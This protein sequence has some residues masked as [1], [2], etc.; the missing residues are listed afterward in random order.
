MELVEIFQRRSQLDLTAVV[1]LDGSVWIAV[2][3][4]SST[5]N[6]LVV[7]LEYPMERRG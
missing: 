2:E 4:Y 5:V 3:A 7:S 1:D 6:P